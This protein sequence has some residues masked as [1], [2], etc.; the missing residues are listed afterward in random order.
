MINDFIFIGIML[1]YFYF[2]HKKW[3]VVM[4]AIST[5]AM[6]SVGIQ[7]IQQDDTVVSLICMFLSLGQ[8]Y[9]LVY[10]ICNKLDVEICFEC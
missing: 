9:Q 1:L 2:I 4:F 6:F 10:E 8:I 7:A 3:S 5:I